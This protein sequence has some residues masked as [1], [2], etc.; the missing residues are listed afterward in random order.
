M[1][2]GNVT[3]TFIKGFNIN[4]STP[5][6]TPEFREKLVKMIKANKG[7]VPLTMMLVDPQ[8]GWKIEFLSRKFKV[9]VTD[10]LI[11]DVNALKIKYN[12]LKK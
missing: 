10:Q 5:M 7:T 9:A 3:D 4:I 6:L 2:L 12:V 1:L 8:T 11:N